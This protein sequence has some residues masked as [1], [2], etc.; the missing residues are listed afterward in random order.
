MKSENRIEDI[1]VV[2]HDESKSIG[3]WTMDAMR[4]EILTRQRL[5]VDNSRGATVTGAIFRSAVIAAVG[6]GRRRPWNR[7]RSSA[8]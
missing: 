2:E 3:N 8:L 1:A 7:A 4:E 6:P 5:D